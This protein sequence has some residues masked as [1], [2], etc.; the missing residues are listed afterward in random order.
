MLLSNYSTIWATT[1][2]SL[3]VESSNSTSIHILWNRI[4]CTERNGE[5]TG[6]NI[7]CYPTKYSNYCKSVYV[8]GTSEI[9]QHYTAH[10]LTPVT[11]YT[12]VVAAV[13]SYNE[14]SLSLSAIITSWTN[15][16]SG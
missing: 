7:T 11:Q 4:S 14:H 9:D 2:M 15:G 10:L 6:Y 1:V 13:S 8:P 16:T 3:C 12:F 5:I